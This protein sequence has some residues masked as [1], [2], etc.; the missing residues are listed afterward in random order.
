MSLFNKRVIG[1]ENVLS[2]SNSRTP[3][4]DTFYNLRSQY[5]FLRLTEVLVP[6]PRSGFQQRASVDTQRADLPSEAS[7][8][9][10]PKV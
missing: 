7:Q 9:F 1:T 6:L 5:T 10:A 2:F 4:G 8:G 3:R